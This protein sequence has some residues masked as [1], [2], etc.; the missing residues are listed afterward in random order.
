MKKFGFYPALVCAMLFLQPL[1]A[2]R[3]SVETAGAVARSQASITPRL[4]AQGGF[5]LSCTMTKSVQKNRAGLRSASPQEEPVYYVFTP[6]GGQGF[7]IVAGDDVAAPV[8]G[9]SDEG[10]F[11]ESNAG[12]MY[13]MESLAQEI[14]GAIENDLPQ[15]AKTKARWQAFPG[16]NPTVGL[17][18]SGDVVEPLLRT[19]WDQQAPYNEYCPVIDGQQALTGCVATAMAQIMCYHRWPE[20]RMATLP[21]YTAPAGNH[22]V[23]PI[24]SATY[25]WAE[26]PAVCTSFTSEAA[27]RTVAALLYDCG[28]A[29]KMD[30]GSGSSA[31][32]TDVLPALFNYFRYD[33]GAELCDRNAYAHA[34]WVNLLKSELQAKRPVYYR[35]EGTNGGHAFVCDGYDAASLFHF[36]WGWGGL[37][38]GYFEL[39][40]LNPAGLGVTGGAGG[41]NS[42]QGMI[43]G[44]CPRGTSGNDMPAIS[45]GLTS[46]SANRASLNGLA[47]TFNVT[48]IRLKNTGTDT[49]RALY[50][51]L[52]L[53][54]SDQKPITYQRSS[55]SPVPFDT[56]SGWLPNQSYASFP[57]YTDYTFP[58]GMP[59]GVYRLYPAF[60]TVSAPDEPVIITANNGGGFIEAVLESGGKVTLTGTSTNRPALSLNAVSVQGRFYH[61]RN[62]Q[63]TVSVTNSGTGDYQSNL[64]IK[65]TNRQGEMQAL[66]NDPV[67]IP[68][69]TTKTL[70][71]SGHITLPADTWHALSVL[72]DPNNVRA[73]PN[74]L[75]GSPV[76]G[77][78]VHSTPAAPDLSA[79]PTLLPNTAVPKDKPNLSFQI[80]N[81]GGLFDG[82]VTARIHDGD[83]Q[84]AL[85]SFSN[86]RVT[87]DT[88]G[89]TTVVFNDPLDHLPEG[90][91]YRCQLYYR[92][93]HAEGYLEPAHTFRL[94][95]AVDNAAIP[96]CR[97]W[98]TAYTLHIAS[99]K[100]GEARIYNAG[101]Q[102][103]KS[104]S[105]R[106]GE[107]VSVTLA[108]G[109]YVVATEEKTYKLSIGK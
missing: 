56:G 24:P 80:K 57:L 106:A 32:F 47:D 104:V 77:F 55:E 10:T 38:D 87:L 11:D 72:Y 98:T 79:Y 31:W 83:S 5:K 73:T 19:R 43:T 76:G 30:Y 17:R 41:F 60:S 92:D 109:F 78:P 26:M 20:R 64:L 33:D 27:N 66:A 70:V 50:F 101:G 62:G 6:E 1:Q 37:S 12:L 3:V 107:T 68:V 103:V 22:T 85:G 71:F 45:L 97:V 18:A 49:I 28:V 86:R 14:A 69:G 61:D 42:Y 13:W 52:L 82:I 29:T 91:T 48:A 40:A 35:G 21:G 53:C 105:C 51:G 102:L 8:L 54:F 4:R 58:L 46:L 9:Y 36:N 67:V 63:V 108:K 65:L 44:I 81:S 88:G 74:T 59:P 95:A 94:T 2:E 23:S 90:V 39:S 34:D 84:E 89:E 75:L 100:S 99:T 25:E 15:D 96:R 93:A 7:V 16:E